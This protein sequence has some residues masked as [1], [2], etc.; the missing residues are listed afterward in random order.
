MIRIFLMK[1]RR[2]NH[3]PS[4]DKKHLA[5]FIQRYEN[6]YYF[7][8]E[9]KDYENLK[10]ILLMNRHVTLNCLNTWIKENY[11]NDKYSK[12]YIK[13]TINS[14]S[15]YCDYL[16]G[17][18]LYIRLKCITPDNYLLV[19]R[20]VSKE[21][22]YLILDLRDSMGGDVDAAVHIVDLFA[23]SC[24]I[25]KLDYRKKTVIYR[26]DEQN[27]NYKNIFIFVNNSTM[28]SA[29]LIMMSLFLNLSTAVI[30]GTETYK[31]KWGQ[32]T[33]SP[34]DAN[35]SVS[36]TAFQ[37][38]VGNITIDEFSDKITQDERFIK[39]ETK[40]DYNAYMQT[41]YEIIGFVL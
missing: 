34:K 28:S 5:Q 30:I 9:I 33:L 27:H 12:A 14:N 7:I 39:I 31:K 16:Y 8:N 17:N 29:E 37:W 35:Y 10:E 25:C 26:A 13:Q 40:A 19:K 22:E 20:A 32:I 36:Y 18:I 2:I 41:V 11:M 23:R 38:K 3:N 21:T 24:N 1:I 6:E 4:I 15:F